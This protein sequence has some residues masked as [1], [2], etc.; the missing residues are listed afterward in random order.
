MLSLD[1]TLRLSEVLLACALLQQGAEH[2]R[3]RSDER[4]LFGSRMLAAGLLLAGWHTPWAL[5]ALVIIGGWSIWRFQ[6]PYNGGSDLM[7]LLIT[8]CLCAARLAPTE[9]WRAVALG[10]LAIQLTISYFQSGWV[11]LLNAEWRS[12]Q[13]LVDVFAFTAYPVSEAT[14]RWADHPALMRA[15]A[16]AVFGFELLFPLALLNRTSL[17]FA[18]FIAASFHL[19]NAC[20]FGLNRFFW[21]WLCAYPALLWWQGRFALFLWQ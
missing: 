12:G 14:R 10:Y 1:A 5:S 17:I 6:G 16:W 8:A 21:I 15:M 18:L 4:W 2:S 19:A 20:L 9:K 13:A 11:K 3:A 7:T